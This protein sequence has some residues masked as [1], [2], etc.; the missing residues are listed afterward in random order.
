MAIYYSHKN[1]QK[2]ISGH[3]ERIR[4]LINRGRSKAITS[5]QLSDITGLPDR[6]IRL[7]IRELIADGLPVLSATETPAGYYLP[8]TR[9]EIR[10]YA[11]ALRSRLIEDARRRRDIL[12]YGDRYLQPARQER[13]L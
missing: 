4:R 11:Q 5:R 7:I 3:K 13:L 9:Q 6:K 2:S 12:I 8:E 1:D 10:Q